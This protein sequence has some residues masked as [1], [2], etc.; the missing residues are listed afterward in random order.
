MWSYHISTDNAW[1]QIQNFPTVILMAK[2]NAEE[3]YCFSN[4]KELLLS[5][6]GIMC[7]EF[8]PRLRNILQRLL[9]IGSE[10]HG[11]TRQGWYCRDRCIPPPPAPGPDSTQR[12]GTFHLSALPSVSSRWLHCLISYFIESWLLVITGR[13][14]CSIN[15]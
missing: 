7:S 3:G 15:G 14:W 4:G 9:L 12:W 6:Q 1:E 13:L 8:V 2:L 10:G 5:W 11:R